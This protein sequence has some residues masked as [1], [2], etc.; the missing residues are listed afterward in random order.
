MDVKT[1]I[2]SGDAG[3]LRGLLAEDPS[4]ANALIVWGDNRGDGNCILTHPLHYVCD[5]L[6]EGTLPMGR[7]LPLIE[8]LIEAGA[9]LDFQRDGRRGKNDTPL[10]GAASLGAEEVGL[11][12]LDAGA[13]PERRG[14][15]GETALHWAALLG[16]DRLAGRLMAG[17]DV[18]LRD[19]KYKSTPLGWAIH[20]WRNPPAGNRGRQRE[21][22]ALL[23]GAGAEVE[24]EWLESEEVRGDV[25]MLAA[26][27]GGRP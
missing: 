6:F 17:S 7:E 24:A 11:R 3:A 9:D 15:F 22:V 12:L 14:M 26:L 8:A 10:I 16:E 18:N 25:E 27:R 20:G 4:R 23:V 2:R 5:M 13:R 1:A 21:V 19:E